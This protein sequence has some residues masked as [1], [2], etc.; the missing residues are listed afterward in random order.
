L[1]S[2][3]FV[4]ITII[5]KHIDAFEYRAASSHRT[6]CHYSKIKDF[7]SNQAGVSVTQQSPDSVIKV[8]MTGTNI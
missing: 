1:Y 2:G 8:R 4:A 6:S 5:F 7:F 3:D